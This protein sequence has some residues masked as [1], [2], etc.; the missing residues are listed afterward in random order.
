MA[1]N[2]SQW[3]GGSAGAPGIPNPPGRASGMSSSF[4]QTIGGNQNATP[5]DPS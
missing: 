1:T 3:F 4:A 5:L 2:Q